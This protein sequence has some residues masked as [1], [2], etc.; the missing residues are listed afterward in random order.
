MESDVPSD[1][2]LDDTVAQFMACR[3][4]NEEAEFNVFKAAK[5]AYEKESENL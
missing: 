3:E 5:E 1:G 2:D 4:E